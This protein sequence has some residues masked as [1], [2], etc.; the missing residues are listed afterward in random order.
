MSGYGNL[1]TQELLQNSLGTPGDQDSRLFR[2]NW[3]AREVLFG[4]AVLVGWRLL[5]I[6][7]SWWPESLPRPVTFFLT[8]GFPALWMIFYPVLVARGR[9]VRDLFSEVNSRRVM[10]E[11]LLTLPIALLLM[12]ALAAASAAAPRSPR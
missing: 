11:L 3:R 10:K 5:M 9:G 2:I 12:A 4:L 6:D 7:R 1:D 8:A